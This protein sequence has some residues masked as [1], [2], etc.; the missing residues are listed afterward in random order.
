MKQ[1]IMYILLGLD[2]Y[3]LA[4]ALVKSAF[5]L[6]SYEESREKVNSY[7]ARTFNAI[8]KELGVTKETQIFIYPTVPFTVATD[9]SKILNK[10]EFNSRFKF[11][12]EYFE[13]YF[14]SNYV[15]DRHSNLCHVYLKAGFPKEKYRNNMDSLRQIIRLRLERVYSIL[16]ENNG[17]PLEN[18]I[19]VAPLTSTDKELY[20]SIYI[21]YSHI[22][23]TNIAKWKQQEYLNSDSNIRNKPKQDIDEEIDDEDS[24]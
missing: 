6:K 20:F 21:A 7:I 23:T 22:G 18:L 13:G 19:F 4:I 2:F 11:L 1:L 14:I 5:K 15:N 12:N 24:I 16:P 9:G 8:L 3:F 17:F 10:P